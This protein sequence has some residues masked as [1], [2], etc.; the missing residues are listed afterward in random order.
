MQSPDHGP[1][2]GMA[3]LWAACAVAGL[4]V[5]AFVVWTLGAA[6]VTRHRAEHAADLAALAAAGAADRGQA[7]A[8]V[9]AAHISERMQVRLRMCRFDG[10]DALVMV[11]VAGPTFLSRFG[12]A[13]ARARAGPVE[14]V[15]TNG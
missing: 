8:C 4:L 13:T 5:V 1:D 12:P 15:T 14:R 3:S 7:E 2:A 6:A 11:E 9:R 10:W